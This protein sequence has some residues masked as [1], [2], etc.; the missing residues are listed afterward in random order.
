VSD[1]ENGYHTLIVVYFV[2]KTVISGVDAPTFKVLEYTTP[3]W[4][5]FFDKLIHRPSYALADV[6]RQPGDGFTSLPLEYEVIQRPG[7]RA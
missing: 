5:R 1:E 4:T 3:W 2:D 7:A 6:V